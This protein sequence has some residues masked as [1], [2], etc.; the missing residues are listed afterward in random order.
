M[1]RAE[2]RMKYQRTDKKAVANSAL[3]VLLALMLFC[4]VRSVLLAFPKR[5][6][7]YN[8]ELY[9]LSMAR[10]FWTEGSFKVY[11]VRTNFMKVLYPII[12]SP[13]YGIRNAELRV[14]V[15]SV[16]SGILISS[17][18]IPFYLMAKRILR[19]N[20]QIILL[21]LI[22]TLWPD[23]LFGMTFMAESLYIPLLA[24]AF[25]AAF[26]EFSKPS[27][28]GSVVCGLLSSALYIAKESGMSFAGGML[29]MLIYQVFREKKQRNPRREATRFFSYLVF[30]LIPI[31]LLKLA[32]FRNAGYS[33]EIQVSVNHLL[34][35]GKAYF[36]CCAV[37]TLLMFF[38]VS[39]QLIPLIYPAIKRRSFSHPEQQLLQLTI[40]C[41]FWISLGTA[42]GVS[43]FEKDVHGVFRIHLRYFC[44]LGY[45]FFLFF[46]KA[47][48][49]PDDPGI[50]REIL[51]VHILCVL[52]TLVFAKTPDIGSEVDHPGLYVMR[53][54]PDNVRPYLK[55]LFA[56]LLGGSCA[57]L[58]SG[59]KNW[60]RVFVA[61]LLVLACV[62]GLFFAKDMK[63]RQKLPTSDIQT[64]IAR[65]NRELETKDTNTCILTVFKSRN[66]AELLTWDLYSNYG[67]FFLTSNQLRKIMD[68]GRKKTAE[69]SY[70]LDE[71]NIAAEGLDGLPAIQY[72]LTDDAELRLDPENYEDI[73]PEGVSFAHLYSAKDS[74][75]I[76]MR[77]K[78][79]YL[80]GEIISFQKDEATF[81]QYNFSGFS[82]PEP[83]FTWSLGEETRIVLRPDVDAPTDM[84]LRWTW[85]STL[86]EQRC[87]L[88]AGDKV[89]YDSVLPD[90]CQL[91]QKVPAD[92]Y[93][94]NGEVVLRF[95]F[96]D[97]RKPGNGD[98]RVLGVAF[99]TLR[100]DLAE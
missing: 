20:R 4:I 95:F 79:D 77:Y 54:L 18:M 78:D 50:K 1:K 91:I 26:L 73:T 100:L 86:G 3:W 25:Y 33:Y 43:A 88:L 55:Y 60:C 37:L 13:F 23:Q 96:P 21:L 35:P 68:T 24:W 27:V 87:R 57:V 40:L 38:A 92:A 80:P 94:E 14:R 52:L 85:Y 90:S 51:I 36:F 31:V 65:I 64:E 29:C 5:A 82:N 49:K 11:N 56:L 62:N 59:K 42:F 70:S 47:H 72:I 19:S 67:A 69:I 76:A 98:S 71:L 93:N 8:D 39:W 28:R 58:L 75:V 41:T 45:L 32:F 15:I 46:L 48:E 84:S 81:L 44:S 53:Y 17:T 16:F 83:R 6:S 12:L 7:I 99:E 22:I 61:V 30:F 2:G 9:Y 89:I 97:A 74:D 34:S 10:S 66:S 63:Q